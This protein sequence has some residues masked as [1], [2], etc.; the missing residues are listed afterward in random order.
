M[1][2]IFLFI[3]KWVQQLTGG[4]YCKSLVNNSILLNRINNDEFGLIQLSNYQI[5][6]IFL[7]RDVNIIL[8]CII[9]K[10]VFLAQEV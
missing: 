6:S 8:L 9:K 2:N 1:L 5:A 3:G 10:V 4:A 7:P